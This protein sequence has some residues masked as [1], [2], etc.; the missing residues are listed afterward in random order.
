M[1]GHTARKCRKKAKQQGRARVATNKREHSVEEESNEIDMEDDNEIYNDKY[2][3]DM[4][5]DNDIEI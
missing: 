2:E 4:E 1:Q 3:I 5:D